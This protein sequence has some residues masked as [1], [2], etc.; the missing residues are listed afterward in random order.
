MENK[1]NEF[2]AAFLKAQMVF[3][4][5]KESGENRFFKGPDG[6]PSTYSTLRD[7]WNAV[8]DALHDNGFMIMQSMSVHEVSGRNI[9]TTSLIHVSGLRE[10]SRYLLPH[11]EEPQK[12]GSAL[13]YFRRYCL[14]AMLGV[15]QE[16]DDAEGTHGRDSNTSHEKQTYIPSRSAVTAPTSSQEYRVGIK[17]SR[18]FGKTLD[19]AGDASVLD[20]YRYWEV[21]LQ[22]EHAPA[23]GEVKRFMD[24]VSAW[25]KLSRQLTLRSGDNPDNEDVSL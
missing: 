5:A 23:T 13:T 12:A 7:I 21:R 11:F 10:N 1:E 6:K 4:E 22:K 14:A 18:N 9:L 16:D 17:T 2:N 19:E 25:K 3:K 20:E 24:A 15:V 8:K